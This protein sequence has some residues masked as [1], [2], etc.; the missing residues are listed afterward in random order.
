MSSRFFGGNLRF[1]G[2]SGGVSRLELVAS[3]DDPGTEPAGDEGNRASTDI[4]NATATEVSTPPMTVVVVAW[5]T[6]A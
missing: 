1:T 2:G 6:S 5:M 4:G 3:D